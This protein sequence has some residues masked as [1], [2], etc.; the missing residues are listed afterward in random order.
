MSCY[1]R[2]R[3]AEDSGHCCPSVVRSEDSLQMGP[4]IVHW[5]KNSSE[6]EQCGV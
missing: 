5:S 1:S 2:R 6:E 4:F 3:G